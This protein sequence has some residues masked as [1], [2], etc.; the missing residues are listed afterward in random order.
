MFGRITR[1]ALQQKKRRKKKRVW[2]KLAAGWD[3]FW[4]GHAQ[5][6]GWVAESF[7]HMLVLA[8]YTD[9]CTRTVPVLHQVDSRWEGSIRT[10]GNIPVL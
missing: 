1:V 6:L 3:G 10:Q 2:F 9:W 5:H 4:G 7:R 8:H